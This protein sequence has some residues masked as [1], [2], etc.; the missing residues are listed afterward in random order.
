MGRG[1]RV[2]HVLRENEIEELRGRLNSRDRF[3]P[4]G[5]CPYTT[6]GH[7]FAVKRAHPVNV[8][9]RD[10]AIRFLSSKVCFSV[11]SVVS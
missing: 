1:K 2:F 4:T 3:P 11:E 6:S 5:V 9:R 7:L 8:M 10:L